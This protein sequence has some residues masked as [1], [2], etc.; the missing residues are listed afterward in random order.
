MKTLLI[1]LALLTSISSFAAV[2][3]PLTCTYLS[4]P[5]DF[6]DVIITIEE[7]PDSEWIIVTDVN[8]QEQDAYSIE[9][10]NENELLI[11]GGADMYV[12]SY[13][14]TKTGALF[15]MLGGHIQV[16]YTCKPGLS[17]SN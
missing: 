1:G 15:S 16:N 10:Q 9:N 11:K 17:S 12:N 2:N 8:E 6:K 5:S 4:G 14:I 13:L 3:L 7:S